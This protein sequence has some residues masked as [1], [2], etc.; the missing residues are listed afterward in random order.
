MVVRP[1]FMKQ[2]HLTEDD[3]SGSSHEASVHG[4]KPDDIIQLS[5]PL[6]LKVPLHIPPGWRRVESK[7]PGKAA[8]VPHQGCL[9]KAFV[10]FKPMT[11]CS[12][13]EASTSTCSARLGRFSGCQQIS[14][15]RRHTG[16]TLALHPIPFNMRTVYMMEC[17][18]ITALYIAPL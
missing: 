5:N 13:V 12:M 6:C 14:S 11:P 8:G 17:V 9:R 2:D 18:C 15:T 4:H 16:S 1:V 7:M 10:P 3:Q